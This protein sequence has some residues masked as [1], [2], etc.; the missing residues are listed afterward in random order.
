MHPVIANQCA[1][2]FQLIHQ[3]ATKPFQLIHTDLA[4]PINPIAKGGFRYA[5]TF[6]DDYYGCLFTYFI[7]GKLDAVKA[8]K[9]FSQTLLHTVM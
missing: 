4:G 8:T 6:T 9:N 2:P 3:R 1:E 5:V 7:K